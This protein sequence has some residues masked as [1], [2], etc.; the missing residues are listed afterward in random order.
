MKAWRG[1][2]QGVQLLQEVAAAADLASP[3]TCGPPP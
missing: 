3:D 2:V 1:W